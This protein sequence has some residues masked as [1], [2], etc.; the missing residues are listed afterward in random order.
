MW[1]LASLSRCYQLRKPSFFVPRGLVRDLHYPCAMSSS[2]AHASLNPSTDYSSQPRGTTNVRGGG[3]PRRVSG[4]YEVS[5]RLEWSSTPHAVHEKLRE[6]SM[7]RLMPQRGLNG[8]W[9]QMFGDAV[10]GLLERE[11]IEQERENIS[12]WARRAP[13]CS[14]SFA[15][16]MNELRR[17]GP[18]QPL[19]YQWLGEHAERSALRRYLEQQLAVRCHLES[20]AGQAELGLLP[21]GCALSF[22]SSTHWDAVEGVTSRDT[23]RAIIDEL[24]GPRRAGSVESW[25]GTSVTN[26]LVG[27]VCNPNYAFQSA[28][29]LCAADLHTV[30]EAPAVVRALSR[31][32]VKSELVQRYRDCVAASERRLTKWYKDVIGPL[33]EANRRFV[34]PTAEGAL[35]LLNAQARF[36]RR[37]RTD[38]AACR[39]NAASAMANGSS[40]H[41]TVG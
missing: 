35:M 33:V 27:L 37:C 5:Q 16:W 3:D 32:Q 13:A 26:L 19:L 8:T 30:A 15:E 38:A 24:G 9:H 25:E 41:S 28:G 36:L 39:T 4:V 22:S 2:H 18:G 10:D 21:E 14:D 7:R 1:H 6:Y 29:A 23:L 31:M 20:L 34:T 11:F 17:V 12:G 40:S